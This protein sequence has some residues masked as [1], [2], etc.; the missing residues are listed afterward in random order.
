MLKPVDEAPS[1][2]QMRQVKHIIQNRNV[3]KLWIL[4]A[5]FDDEEEEEKGCNFELKINL[6]DSDT[7]HASLVALSAPIWAEAEQE[8]S[9]EYWLASCRNTLWSW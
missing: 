7:L 6:G 5:N 2:R 9:R 8:L 3:W 1:Q 4:S